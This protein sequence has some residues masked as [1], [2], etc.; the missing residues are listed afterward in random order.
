[1][2]TGTGN[3]HLDV[4]AV[5]AAVDQGGSVVLRGH[6]SFHKPPNLPP[7]SI[8]KRM[9]TVSNEVTITGHPDANGHLPI[10]E[11]GDWPFL[12]DAGNAR[13]TIHKLHFVRPKSGAIWIYSVG[14]LLIRGCH[15]ERVQPSVEFGMEGGQTNAVA[16]AIFA[17]AD[18]HPP[19]AIN[20]GTPGDFSGTLAIL[21][22]DIDV[23]GGLDVDGMSVLGVVMFRLGTP[24]REVKIVVSG[25]TIRNVT[26][27]AI[28]LRVVGG[29]AHAEQNVLITGNISGMNPDVIRVFGSGSYVIARNTIDCGWMGGTATGI[30]LFSQQP[31]MAPISNAIVVD[32]D[33]TM[34]AENGTVS[35]DL[36][37]GIKMKGFAQGSLVL[38]NRIRGRASA[39]LS[40]IDLNGGMPASNWLL[41]NDVANFHS[42]VADVFIDAGVTDTFVLGHQGSLIDHGVGTVVVPL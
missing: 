5:Q 4:P 25:N 36:S 38:N 37:A 34:S 1:M 30:D 27:P 42:S 3:P 6:F 23:G 41:L 33:V 7:G 40:L 17:G 18:P 9:V 39:A 29:R 26:A 10:I 24:D 11:A 31:P 19:N 8:Y 2:V 14:G 12:I 32:N 15:I 21:N 20:P 35:T 16:A 13:V 28:N 22:N